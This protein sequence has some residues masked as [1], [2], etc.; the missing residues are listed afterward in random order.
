MVYQVDISNL[1][2]RWFS[3]KDAERFMYF[4]KQGMRN[5]QPIPEIVATWNKYAKSPK[6]HVWVNGGE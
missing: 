1:L 2:D 5:K 4:M 6:Q 3:L